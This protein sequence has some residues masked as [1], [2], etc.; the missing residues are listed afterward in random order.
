MSFIIASP[1]DR[2]VNG[3]GLV[4][5]RFW[6]PPETSMAGLVQGDPG[7]H[8]AAGFPYHLSLYVQLPGVMSPFPWERASPQCS[9][10]SSALLPPIF[11]AHHFQREPS[12]TYKHS[13]K[14]VRHA[15]W[16]ATL[17]A[18]YKH[19]QE[20]NQT[21]RYCNDPGSQWFAHQWC[22]AGQA[23]N[24]CHRQDQTTE[25]GAGNMGVFGASFKK[26]N[27]QRK[28]PHTRKYDT[29][30]K[31]AV[32]LLIRARMSSQSHPAGLWES[33]PGER[34]CGCFLKSSV[35]YHTYKCFW[36]PVAFP[37][38][39]ELT[40][41]LLQFTCDCYTVLACFGFHIRETLV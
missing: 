19:W 27:V 26:V 13:N 10:N 34:P 39:Q 29:K 28:R 11:K 22:L 8:L 36:F 16:E 6:A 3:V 41:G 25:S 35:H 30:S 33:S 17:A 9:S 21:A 4:K 14:A 40:S 37:S 24:E 7:Y 5:P 23:E 12:P 2:V 20:E 15:L 18:L 1:P 38:F 32:S 31:Q